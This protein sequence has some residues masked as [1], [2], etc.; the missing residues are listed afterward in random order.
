MAKGRGPF[1]PANQNTQQC[2]ARH[3]LQTPNGRSQLQ[4]AVSTAAPAVE[5]TVTCAAV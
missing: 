1:P 4:V 3:T 2:T 5:Q